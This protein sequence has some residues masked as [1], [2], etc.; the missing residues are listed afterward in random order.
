[1]IFRAELNSDRAGDDDSQGVV[2]QCCGK[3]TGKDTDAV[4]CLAAVVDLG[5]DPVDEPLDAAILSDQADRTGD[6]CCCDGDGEHVCH[7]AADA[8][9]PLKE[10]AGTGREADD[11]GGDNADEQNAGDVKSRKSGHKNDQIGK[12]LDDAEGARFDRTGAAGTDHGIKAH[13]NERCGK[14]DPQVCKELVAH[15]GAAALC[16]G[17][18]GIGDHGQVITKV[19][20]ADNCRCGDRGAQAGALRHAQGYRAHCGDGAHGGTDRGGDQTAHQ[21]YARDQELYGDIMKRHVDDGFLA[22]H[23]GCRSLEA[24][25]HEVDQDDLHDAGVTH[26][27]T[28]QVC[29]LLDRLAGLDQQRYAETDQQCYVTWKCAEGA[30]RSHNGQDHA[31]TDIQ[32]QE[33]DQR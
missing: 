12:D 6:Q 28:E 5:S 10:A 4:L 23:G 25:G 9:D 2:D 31:G 29:L 20:T 27:F 21:E 26:M 15:L 8:L 22:A 30:L 11:T 18:R 3:D 17:N 16:R 19:G 14:S 13:G 33:Y 1:M 7:A 32:C 24:A